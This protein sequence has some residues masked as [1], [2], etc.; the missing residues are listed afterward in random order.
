[1]SV[2]EANH[3]E[4]AE[5][6]AAL[7]VS[8]SVRAFLDRFASSRPDPQIL[9]G[10]AE[11]LEQLANK[12]GPTVDESRR[13]IGRLSES[14]C[15]EPAF[16]P[17]VH[18]VTS[19]DNHRVINVRFGAHHLGRRGAIMALLDDVFGHFIPGDHSMRHRTVHFEIDFQ[20]PTPV[21][22]IIGVECTL[23]GREGRKLD[24][25]A[26]VRQGSTV[27]ATARARFVTLEPGQ[28]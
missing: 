22:E 10:L 3:V 4:P 9:L 7:R 23:Q 8:E 1:M 25:C 26:E 6:A 24:V 12:L 19:D 20:A 27:C 21:D 11:E 15:H 18:V 16:V 14:P 17:P 2:L 28:R 5:V 13:I